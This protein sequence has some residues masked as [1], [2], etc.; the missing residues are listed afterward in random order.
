MIRI[1]YDY[2]FSDHA[3]A[4]ACMHIYNIYTYIFICIPR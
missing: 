4:H 1:I 3:C 2:N